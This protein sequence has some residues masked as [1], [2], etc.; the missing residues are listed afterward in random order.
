MVVHLKMAYD[1]NTANKKMTRKKDQ[2]EI[3]GGGK[4]RYGT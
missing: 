4:Q 2:N 1:V 3:S